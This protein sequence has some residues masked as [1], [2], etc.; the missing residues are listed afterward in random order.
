MSTDTSRSQLRAQLRALHDDWRA[1]GSGNR[2]EN[3][4]AAALDV[5]AQADPSWRRE[6]VIVTMLQA[7]LSAWRQAR[8]AADRSGR[9]TRPDAQPPLA[10]PTLICAICQRPFEADRSSARTCSSACRQRAYRH[11]RMATATA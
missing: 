6:Q 7:E 11:R 9:R 1:A 8:R 5:I 3:F 2:P 10:P 4:L